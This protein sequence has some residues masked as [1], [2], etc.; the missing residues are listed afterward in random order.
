MREAKATLYS[1]L[2][3]IIKLFALKV[4]FKPKSTTKE[5]YAKSITTKPSI[6]TKANQKAILNF[7][8][9]S[10]NSCHT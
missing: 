1:R 9:K 2:S 3:A 5:H 6:I 10:V 4:K 8:K 7:A